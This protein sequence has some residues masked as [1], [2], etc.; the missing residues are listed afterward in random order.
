MIMSSLEI[1]GGILEMIAN[2]DD[3]E[4]LQELKKL[5][6]AF[7]GNHIKD[8]DYW[9]ELTEYEQSELE[10]AIIDSQDEANHVKH[11]EVVKKYKKWLGR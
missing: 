9:E 6:A 2:I 8:S 10:Q 3:V 1:K 4:S 7:V 5:V 11:E